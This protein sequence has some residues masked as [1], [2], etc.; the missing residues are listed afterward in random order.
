MCRRW[1]GHWLLIRGG[2]VRHWPWNSPWNLTNGQ[3]IWP[4]P[5]TSLNL[6]HGQWWK[7]LFC[8]QTSW[9][10]RQFTTLT[11]E[12]LYFVHG[13]DE[14]WCFLVKFR[15]K[16]LGWPFWLRKIWIS[17]VVMVEILTIWPWLNAKILAMVT[18]KIFDHW[19]WHPDLAL[20]LPQLHL[21]TLFHSF[22][23]RGVP[24]VLLREQ[25]GRSDDGLRGFGGRAPQPPEA[26]PEPSVYQALKPPQ[27]NI[28]LT[29]SLK[30]ESF[31]FPKIGLF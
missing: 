16:I 12:N 28:D 11:I 22:V 7:W 27:I 6:P 1:S 23:C 5:L 31:R 10:D 3:K 18:V 24:W 17:A 19:P 21:G 9:L 26:S 20:P 13:H 4:W 8:S 30:Y 2:G 25:L 15:G 29:K 14:N